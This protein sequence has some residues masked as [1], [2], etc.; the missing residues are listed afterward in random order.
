MFRFTRKDISI[1][2]IFYDWKISV[3]PLL[4]APSTAKISKHELNTLEQQKKAVPSAKISKHELDT[5]EQQKKDVRK[6]KLES[7]KLKNAKK[8]KLEALQQEV[9]KNPDKQNEVEAMEIEFNDVEKERVALEAEEKRLDDMTPMNVDEE[10]VSATAQQ[11]PSRTD[12]SQ[13]GGDD[14]NMNKE[15]N[16]DT[17]INNDNNSD[18]P[19]SSDNE[20][21]PV[22]TISEYKKRTG[23]PITESV[24]VAWKRGG[25]RRGDTVIVRYGPKSHPSFRIESAT[26]SFEYTDV[27]DILEPGY[28]IGER[29]S[30]R[31]WSYDYKNVDGIVAVAYKPRDETFPLDTIDPAW[32]ANNPGKRYGE[33]QVLIQWKNIDGTKDDP[34]PR[35][36][37]TR[38]TARRVC[39]IRG[40][41]GE[42]DRMLF[43]QAQYCEGK[44]DSW[45][46]G[47]SKGR[48]TTMTPAPPDQLSIKVENQS[49]LEEG[50]EVEGESE[51]EEGS[52]V[53]E[54][55]SKTVEFVN[56]PSASRQPKTSSQSKKPSQMKQS[57]L[58]SAKPASATKSGKKNTQ[59]KAVSSIP[60][61]AQAPTGSEVGTAKA[62]GAPPLNFETWLA[63]YELFYGPKKDYNSAEV[64]KMMNTWDS[65]QAASA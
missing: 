14:D 32:Y 23:K 60:T 16:G 49:E 40:K 46:D 35:S 30:N 21:V 8:Q 41:K 54:T 39:P 28:R 59:P 51:A 65:V 5:L 43:A 64:T 37:E 58:K 48:D 7:I 15:N 61:T 6:K 12:I 2:A 25:I 11:D 62:T 34:K 26:E 63:K 47:R 1:I 38:A 13:G 4:M 42:A 20:E 24:V 31:T 50:S 18:N 27:P 53:E 36:W 3:V 57:S 55:R 22:M 29:K 52:A 9:Q 33:T 45:L 10:P 17:A 19:P 56:P 44:H